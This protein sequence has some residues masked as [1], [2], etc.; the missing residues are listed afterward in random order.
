MKHSTKNS[1]R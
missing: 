1:H